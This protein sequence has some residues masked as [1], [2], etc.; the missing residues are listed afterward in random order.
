LELKNASTKK[1]TNDQ[2]QRETFHSLHEF[3]MRICIRYTAIENDPEQSMYIGFARF[4][5]EWQRLKFRNFSFLK[6]R[7]RDILIS[8]CIQTEIGKSNFKEEPEGLLFP[9][10]TS[11]LPIQ[12]RTL[13]AK[14]IIDILR[15]IPFSFRVIYNM[16]V[17]D[18]FN[19][20][21]ISSTL[22]IPVH[23]VQ[24]RLQLARKYLHELLKHSSVQPQTFANY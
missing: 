10:E 7:L 15:T 5:G 12:S 14:E 13:S 24:N 22:R 17:I 2:A 18:G 4:F 9:D 16:S 21:E 8:V 19:E 23:T 11:A 3:A 20:K 6:S 1:H